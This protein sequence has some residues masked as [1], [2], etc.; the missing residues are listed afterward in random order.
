MIMNGRLEMAL[1]HGVGP[2]K[3]VRFEPILSEEFYFVA[4][5]NFAIEAEPKPVP[6][7]ALDG[8][9]MLLP[10]AYNFVRRAVETAFTRSRINLKV[11][12]EVEIVR[13]LARAVGS[14]LG[15]TI[16]P[17]AIADRIVSESSEPLVCRLV[18]PRIEETL[19]LCTSDQSSLSEPAFAVKDILVE[20]TER[21]KL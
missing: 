10:P 17:K 11:V 4:H 7:G 21:L 12:A 16:M 20:L 2:I 13:T 15:A 18:S 19:S 9:P 1:I 3:G 5:R 6:V 8:M 14:G